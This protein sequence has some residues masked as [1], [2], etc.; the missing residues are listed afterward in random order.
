MWQFQPGRGDY[1]IGVH[2]KIKVERSRPKPL[3]ITSTTE[4]FLYLLK[5][6]EQ[7]TAP[8]PAR[9]TDNRVDK[10]GLIHMTHW[11]CPVKR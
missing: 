9:C 2:Q 3:T 4:A 8:Y 6:L 5:R 1:L 11:R 7:H 10:I